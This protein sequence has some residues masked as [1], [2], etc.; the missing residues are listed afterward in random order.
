MRARWLVSPLLVT[1]VALSAPLALGGPVPAGAASTC[2]ARAYVADNGDGNLS[3]LD[4]ATDTVGAPFVIGGGPQAVATS[5]DGQR[6][7]VTDGSGTTMKVLDAA[8]G[9]VLATVEVGGSPVAL[10]VSPDGHTAYVTHFFLGSTVTV[11]DLDTNAVDGSPIM[12]GSGPSDVAFHPR[13]RTCLRHE[14]RRH[15]GVGD[16]H[17]HPHRDVDHGRHQS[18]LGGGEPRW[19]QGL[20]GPRRAR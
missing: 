15:H 8:T 2:S 10:A 11:V 6:V 17:R 5:P 4:V 19:Q 3:V 14:L 7:Y 13:R 9:T 16:R 1:L 12:V 20:R 18:D